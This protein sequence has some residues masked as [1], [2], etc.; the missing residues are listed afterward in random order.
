MFLPRWPYT[1]LLAPY[2]MDMLE[3]DTSTG[4]NLLGIFGSGWALESCVEM[5]PAWE[6]GQASQ[7]GRL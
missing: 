6:A 3:R 5:M 2:H 4:I 1:H 7:G